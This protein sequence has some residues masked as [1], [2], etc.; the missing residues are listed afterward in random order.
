MEHPAGQS[1]RFARIWT[2]GLALLLASLCAVATAVHAA[3][4]EG[5][6]RTTLKNG[7]R[8][9]VV[10]NTLAAAVSTVMNYHV[11]GNETPP[12]F[13][14][15]AHALEHMMFRGSPGLSAAQLADIGSVM[16]GD[17]NAD[18]QQ[19]VTQ[20]LYSVPATDLDV[21]LNIEAVRMRGLTA[22]ESDWKQER[23]AITQ[24][25]AQDL[26]SPTYML[27]TKLRQALFAGTVYAHDALGTKQ[28][29]LKTSAADLR[30][31][32]QRWYAPNN[33]TLVIVGDVEPEAALAKVRRLFEPI[34]RRKLPPRPQIAL[35]PVKP[36]SLT[37]DS[38]L[39]YALQVIAL[40]MPGFESPDYPAAEV[41]VD[42]LKSRRGKLYDLVPQGK[43]LGTD[44]VFDGLPKAGLGYAVAMFPAGGDAKALESEVRAI[45]SDI[46]KNGVPADLVEA[47]KLQERRGAQVQK[48]SING[49]AMVWSE[50]VAVEGLAS[51][52]EDLERIEKVTVEDVNRV[53]RQYLNLDR[54]VSAVLV[55]RSSGKPVQARGFG[56]G[57]QITLRNPKPT[58]LPAWAKV[59]VERLVVPDSKVRPVVSTLPNGITLIVQPEYVSDT[60]TLYGQVKNRPELQV[61]QGKEGLSEVL[62]E[63]F[64]YGTQELDRVAL[65]RAYDAIG[66]GGQAGAQFHVQSLTEHFEDAVALLAQ[67]ELHPAFPENAFKVVKKQITQTVA[68]RLTSPGYLSGR[69]LLSAVFPKGD[70][71]LREALPATVDSITL[72][73]VRDYYQA[74]FRPDLT[75]IV[76]IGNL[77]PERARAV[78]EKNFGAWS[79]KGPKP[80][81]DLPPVPPNPPSAF[82]V[83][84]A[85]RVQDRVTLAG[86]LNMTRSD[87]DYYALE[88][89]N[90]VLGGSFYSTRLTRDIRMAAGL[91]YAIDSALQVGKTRGIYMVQYACDPQNVSKVHAMVLRELR[92]M[93]DTPVAEWELQRAKAL[94]VHRIPLQESG[95]RQIAQ[96]LIHRSELGLPLD[97]PTI[98]AKRYIE[99][100]AQGVKSAF[101][102]RIRPDDLARVTQGPAPK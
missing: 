10:R 41:L 74:A 46:A 34:P 69:A 66:A 54:S 8:V 85:S 84:D 90:N 55:P 95:V 6:V 70:P 33:A 16:G 81:T 27:F 100:D 42:V 102:K 58:T 59:A 1:R 88:L 71:L 72:Q 3:G 23:G 83:P 5:V 2:F 96:A 92:Q 65:Q 43:A 98:A 25:V 78:I 13:P 29:F 37:L 38:D 32:H 12:G 7:M 51:P 50:A 61:P 22:S 39:P 47:A 76:V 99:L 64:P 36:Q 62:E 63:L 18:T 15:T 44:F 35:R 91:V 101:A 4:V 28:S 14:G 24:E 21:A 45:L 19:T 31:F 53:A 60:V 48:N 86:A 56:G 82:A 94:L 73:D 79:A 80:Q 68:S 26:S 20:Y 9:I 49:L 17:F 11:G 75:T 93:Q 87:P 40:R 97:E 52:D 89:G 57:E 77:T 30:R 67:N